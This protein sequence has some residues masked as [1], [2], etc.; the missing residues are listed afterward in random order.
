M[1]VCVQL[2]RPNG[3]NFQYLIQTVNEEILVCVATQSFLLLPSK[4]CGS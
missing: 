4:N 1:S 2:F 3:V